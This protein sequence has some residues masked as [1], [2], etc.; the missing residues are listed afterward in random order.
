MEES[1]V[2][3]RTGEPVTQDEAEQA[4]H[5]LREW[6]RSRG[7]P[8][9]LRVPLEQFDAILPLFVLGWASA[10]RTGHTAPAVAGVP[11]DQESV[12]RAFRRLRSGRVGVRQSEGPTLWQQVDYHGSV[13]RCHGTYWVCAIHTYADPYGGVPELRYD[14]CEEVDVLGGVPVPVVG[15]V[16]R[17]SLTPLPVHRI[18]V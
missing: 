12:R 18:P 14:L 1:Q 4:E 7:V 8:G 13:R 9:T 16:R 5:A 6:A 10:V 11:V 17:S 15:S 3:D 2:I